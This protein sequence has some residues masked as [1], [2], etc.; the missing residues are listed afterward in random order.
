VVEGGELS[1]P[2]S[3]EEKES[4]LCLSLECVPALE[5]EK[6]TLAD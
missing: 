5:R 3:M 2:H 6:V 4:R 1:P